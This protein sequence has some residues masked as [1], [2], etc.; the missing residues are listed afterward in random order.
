MERVE[1]RARSRTVHGKQVKQLRSQEWVPGVVYGRGIASR[2]IEAQER[3][4]V[5]ALK[6]AGSTTLIDLYV[7]SEPTPNI[8]LAREIQHNAINGRLVHV[9]FYQVRLTEKV[10]TRPHIRFV[11]EPAAVKS[12]L[13]VLLHSMTDIEVECLPTDLINFIEVD[14][15]GL[16]EVGDSIFVRDLVVPAGITVLDDPNETVAS[17]VPTRMAIRA[18]EEEA[19]AVVEAAA[20]TGEGD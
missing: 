6:Q 20:E 10:K 16:Q 4:L 7:D 5:K 13:A 15:S 11:G 2:S 1:L 9:D 19:P 17:V 8:V 3:G 12:G 14:A 18:E